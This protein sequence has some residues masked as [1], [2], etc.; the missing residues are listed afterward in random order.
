MRSKLLPIAA[1][2]LCGAALA[3][4]MYLRGQ[5]DGSAPEI[6]TVKQPVTDRSV[7]VRR[8]EFWLPDPQG[9]RHGVSE[10]DG[11]VLVMNFWATWCPP[12]L[13]EIPMFIALQQRY[14]TRGV[15]FLGIAIDD[16]DQVGAFADEIGLN[17]PTLHGQMDAIEVMSAYGNKSGGLPFTVII[18]QSGLIVARHPGVLDEATATTLIEELL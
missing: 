15:Q 8:P 6:I 13:H 11:K 4:G 1:V 9:V 7:S 18:S 12:C 10:W 16:A 14:E 5:V 17:Y 3:G 2:I